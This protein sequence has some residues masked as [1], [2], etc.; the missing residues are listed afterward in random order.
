MMI[1]LSSTG[2][3]GHSGTSISLDKAD[4]TCTKHWP[5]ASASASLAD[6]TSDMVKVSAG[7][8]EALESFRRRE[9]MQCDLRSGPWTMAYGL[10][11]GERAIQ[12]EQPV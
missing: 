2:A 8:D 10:E 6:A 11:A 12:K 7:P 9:M 3:L 4:A 5:Q 1:S